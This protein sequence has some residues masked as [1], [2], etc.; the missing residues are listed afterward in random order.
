MAQLPDLMTYE[1]R[2]RGYAIDHNH[3]TGDFRGIL[4]LQC[5]SML[6]MAKESVQ[7]LDSAAQYL[8]NRGSY[9]GFFKRQHESGQN[10]MMLSLVTPQD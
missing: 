3:E 2:K 4:C 5:N 6:G 9:A 8:K 10:Q 7:I 1:N